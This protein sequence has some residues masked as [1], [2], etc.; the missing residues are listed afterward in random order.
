MSFVNIFKLTAFE[1]IEDIIERKTTEEEKDFYVENFNGG[2]KNP[3][4]IIAYNRK[5]MQMFIARFL[6]NCERILT[7]LDTNL[8]TSDN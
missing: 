8:Y 7:K 4:N 1:D 6:M 2:P 3:Q 5:I